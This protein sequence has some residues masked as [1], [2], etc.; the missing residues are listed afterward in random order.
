MAR[1]VVGPDFKREGL[2]LYLDAA[3][4]KSYSGTGSIWYDI[5]G[6]KI[7][8]TLQNSP[9]YSTNNLGYFTFDN[10]NNEY[11]TLPNNLMNL[12]PQD[13]WTISVWMY[14]VSGAGNPRVVSIITDNDNLQVGFL[15]TLYPYIRIDGS[16]I[17]STT[18][19][20]DNSWCNVVYSYS[21]SAGLNIHIN[22]TLASTTSGGPSGNAV[23]S[24]VGG[25]INSY[26]MN[27]NIAIVSIYQSYLSLSDINYNFNL[28]R[29]RFGI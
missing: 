18:I 28:F 8:S 24:A 12:T 9:S 5:S 27:G 26:S 14:I 2:V 10:S 15:T 6:N 29:G 11:G 25:G 7:E 22:G 19:L 4:S 3:N 16:S 1:E 17:Y 13:D 20:S 21:S 23:Y